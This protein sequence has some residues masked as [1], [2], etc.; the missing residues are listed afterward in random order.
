VQ[1]RLL[2]GALIRHA[3]PQSSGQD[4]PGV[5]G[6]EF[7]ALRERHRVMVRGPTLSLFAR[8]ETVEFVLA[9]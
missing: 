5:E 1:P 6:V 7:V 3:S 2:V 4:R 9:L 8:T